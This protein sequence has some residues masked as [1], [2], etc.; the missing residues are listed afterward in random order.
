MNSATASPQPPSTAGPALEAP[1]PPRATLRD[2]VGLAVIALPCLLYSMDLT[3][4]N[5]ALPALSADFGPSSTQLLWIVDI[6]GFM[7]AGLLMTMGSLGDRIGRRR[8][9]LIGA[10][11]FGAASVAAA[12]S[13]STG[14][15]IA[16]RAL[17][18]VAGA[19]LA[20]STLSLIRNMFHDP[21]QR[22]V[23]IGVWVSSYSVGAAIGPVVGG[24]L[25]EH[26][27]WGSVFLAGVPV[28][29]L[30]LLLGPWLLPEF[31]DRDAP[32]IDLPSAAL[33]LA[34]VLSLV[35]GVK[36]LAEHGW[37]AWPLLAVAAGATLG[38]VFVRRQQRLLA[39]RIQPMVDVRLF[40]VRSFSVALC[41]YGLSALMGF[42]TFIFIG[43]YLQ[44]VAGMGPLQAGLWTTPFA[45]AFVVG[46]ML[47]PALAR[48]FGVGTTISA[49]LLVATLGFGLLCAVDVLTPPAA[50]AVAFVVYSLG[51][52]PVFTLATDL[53]VGSVPQQ[54]AGAAAA[55]SE[56]FSELGSALG[57]AL[58]GSL[59]AAI[60]RNQ[61]SAAGLEPAWL[62]ASG[63]TLAAAL[64]SARAA[65]GATGMALADAARSAFVAGMRGAAVLAML[66][67][68]ATAWFACHQ[69][70]RQA[71]GGA[72]AEPPTGL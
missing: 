66:T 17:L 28:M 30:L 7:V 16:M 58:L 9:L 4:L 33:S 34:A 36:H 24:A 64:E 57:I 27:W 49:G 50:M 72:V 46:S 53:V 14:M 68:A 37:A 60:Y 29:L 32:A 39:L 20:P 11:A 51:L 5:L 45:A 35:W 41:T 18:G 71:I 63:G 42:G 52:A 62:E 47:T 69:L 15:L 23:A 22:T 48:R 38:V 10:A 3:V 59:G 21:R 12:F 1:P 8:L 26:F 55:L 70:R 19:T 25:L 67:L 54:Q 56:T 43:Q 2:W 6:Y 31:R 13:S 61:M 40:R 65:G 44:L